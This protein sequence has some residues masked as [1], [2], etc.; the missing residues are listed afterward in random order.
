MWAYLLTPFV[1]LLSRADAIMDGGYIPALRGALQADEDGQ[2][3]E[4]GLECLCA[5]PCALPV[6]LLCSAVLPALEALVASWLLI[7]DNTVGTLLQDRLNLL[8]SDADLVQVS[9]TAVP[10]CPTPWCCWRCCVH[11]SSVWPC[12][13][14]QLL[15]HRRAALNSLPH[16]EMDAH[17]EELEHLQ[18]LLAAVQL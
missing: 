14:P 16:E 8:E 9:P 5:S 7:M 12:V 6:S 1:F 15:A 17:Q 2:L 13:F 11:P 10:S 18:C 3:W 4:H